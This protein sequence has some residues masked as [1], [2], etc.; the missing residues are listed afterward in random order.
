MEKSIDNQAKH[1]R[2]LLTDQNYF[3][4]EVMVSRELDNIGCLDHVSGEDG[5]TEKME[6][7]AKKSD[8]LIT[9]YLDEDHLSTIV[10]G[11]I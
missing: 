9:R 8:T 10:S 5:E 7:K 3:V 2:V 11:L 1:Q 6:E 4:W